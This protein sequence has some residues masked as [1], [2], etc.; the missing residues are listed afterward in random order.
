MQAIAHGAA[1]AIVSNGDTN[2]SPCRHTATHAPQWM[3]A[4]QITSNVTG[5]SLRGI[6]VWLMRLHPAH[7]AG[8]RLRRLACGRW[9]IAQCAAGKSAGMFGISL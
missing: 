5:C 6:S 4:G 3:H 8:R 7:A 9:S 1:T 2:G